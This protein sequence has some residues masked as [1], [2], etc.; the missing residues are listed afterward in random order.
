MS[1]MINTVPPQ[2]A[3][4]CA[5]ACQCGFKIRAGLAYALLIS[6]YAACVLAHVPHASLIGEAGDLASCSAAFGT[7]SGNFKMSGKIS[8][9]VCN[10]KYLQSNLPSNRV[11]THC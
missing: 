7:F 8:H 6:R 5:V 11:F 9:D 10:R 3:L 2:P 1:C 4:R